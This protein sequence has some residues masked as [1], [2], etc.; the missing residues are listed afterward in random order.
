MK[1]YPK[2]EP[3]ETFRL[4]TLLFNV[5]LAQHIVKDREPQGHIIVK[6]H[7]SYLS[8]IA[9]DEK[10]AEAMPESVLDIPIIMAAMPDGSRYPIDGH[11]RMHKALKI[12][13]ERL[14]VH[15]LSIEETR[16]CCMTRDVWRHLVKGLG[17]VKA[18][19][20]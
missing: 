9:H 12:G 5:S 14:L 1:R 19:A 2:I 11:H 15:A 8:W 6:D 17:P 3:E 20:R 7:K 4:M 16:A 18:G 10:L 13:R